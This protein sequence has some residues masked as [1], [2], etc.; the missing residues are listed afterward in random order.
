MGSDSEKL[1]E[2]SSTIE[3]TEV[4]SEKDIKLKIINPDNSPFIVSKENQIEIKGVK[5]EISLNAY[6]KILKISIYTIDNL[7][8][9]NSLLNDPEI[10]IRISLLNQIVSKMNEILNEVETLESTLTNRYL[11][12]IHMIRQ[13][14]LE[15]NSTD[16]SSE[17]EDDGNEL[18][19]GGENT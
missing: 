12:L 3:M 16:I 10:L 14:D 5:N 8:S 17:E 7:L 11:D 19:S 15:R 2:S 1:K 18:D 4:M 13:T 6:I 9:D